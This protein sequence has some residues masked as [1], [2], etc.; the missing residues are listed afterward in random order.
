VHAAFG[1]KSGG[2]VDLSRARRLDP[3]SLDPLLARWALAAT[4][5]AGLRPL[6]E[7]V[8]MEPRS[9]DLLYALGRQQVLAGDK[10]AAR[11][12]LE[13][14]LQLDPADPAIVRQLRAARRGTRAA[15]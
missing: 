8:L 15:R 4:P 6:E 7:A 11:R 9:P 14:A 10:P 12:T 13:R 2:A 5:R 3:L 1:S